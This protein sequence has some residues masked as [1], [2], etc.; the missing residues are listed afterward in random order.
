MESD[1]LLIPHIKHAKD[2]SFMPTAFYPQFYA[3]LNGLKRAI[4][5]GLEDFFIPEEYNKWDSM[6]DFYL[7]D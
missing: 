2:L 5:S 1:D 7:Q 6:E 3:N 4:I